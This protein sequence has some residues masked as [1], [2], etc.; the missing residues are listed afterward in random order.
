MGKKHYTGGNVMT[1]SMISDYLA[2]LDCSDAREVCK[3][4]LFRLQEAHLARIP[5]TNLSFY[6]NGNLQSLEIE[7]LFERLIIQ[8]KG[9]YCFELNGLFGELL[10]SLG[11][12]VTEYFARWHF[13]GTEAVPMRRHRVLKVVLDGETFLADAGIGSPCPVT[14]LKF[15][16]DTIQPKNF[17]AYRVVKDPVLGNVVEAETPEGFLP[18][19]SFTEDPHFPQDFVYVHAYCVQQPDSAF[20]TKVFMHKLTAD[21]QWALLNPTPESPEYALRFWHNGEVTLEPIRSKEKLLTI[22][23]DVFGLNYTIEDLPEIN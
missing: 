12:N 15:E 14:P 10:R 20:R 7:A 9:G 4:N 5:Y 22:L 6:K 11:Y 1:E 2:A 8:R 16:Y 13:G 23:T 18:Y 3:E 17:R 21:T 19:F